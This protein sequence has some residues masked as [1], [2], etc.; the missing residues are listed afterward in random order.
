MVH[1]E[2]TRGGL[3]TVEEKHTWGDL[4]KEHLGLDKPLEPDMEKYEKIKPFLLLEQEKAK[5]SFELAKQNIPGARPE[6]KTSQN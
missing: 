5:R 2:Q 3:L 1:W 6:K 4:F